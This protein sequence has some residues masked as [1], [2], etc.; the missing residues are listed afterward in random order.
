MKFC[1]HLERTLF[2]RQWNALS[3]ALQYNEL[4]LGK[5]NSESIARGG[6][7]IIKIYSSIEI[8]SVDSVIYIAVDLMINSSLLGDKQ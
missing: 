3:P 8:I 2:T 7:D 1:I 4:S 5:F 6:V